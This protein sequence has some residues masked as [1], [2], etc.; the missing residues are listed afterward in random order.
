MNGENQIIDN[1]IKIIENRL[2]GK[3]VNPTYYTYRDGIKMEE[4]PTKLKP[5][6]GER[7]DVSVIIPVYKVRRYIRRCI[8]SLVEQTMRSGIEFIFVDDRGDD[9]SIE[10]V[11]EYAK[12]D[13]RIHIVYN[14]ENMGSG[15][16]RNAGI[17]VARGEYLGFVDP[18]DY[19]APNFYGSLIKRVQSIKYDI[20]KATRYNVYQNGTEVLVRY[21]YALKRQLKQQKR[22]YEIFH[23]EHQTAIY[24]RS[25]LEEHPDIRFGNTSAAQDCT[26]LL[27]YSFYAK[28]ITFIFTTSYYYCFRDDSVGNE[29]SYKFY[30]GNIRSMNDRLDFLEK[31][32]EPGKYND[33]LALYKG[34]LNV[35]KGLLLESEIIDDETKEGLIKRFDDVFQRIDD[36]IVPD[37][38][39]QLMNE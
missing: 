26:F 22:L 14:N 13:P 11:E 31:N 7:I 34:I 12:T 35:R 32:A 9:G 25:L 33:Y 23:Y 36:L 16:S 19:V 39:E 27:A 20:V 10:I 8:L 5:K 30:D 24:R 15:P 3:Q 37:Q 28:N 18:D 38:T 1:E 2:F 6:D 4:D 29:M 21:N 17:A